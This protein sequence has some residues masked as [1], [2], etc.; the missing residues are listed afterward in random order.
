MTG[1]GNSDD[2]GSWSK[3][4]RWPERQAGG[5]GKPFGDGDQSYKIA[6]ERLGTTES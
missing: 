2:S 3:G 6:I 5:Q 1:S 4:Q